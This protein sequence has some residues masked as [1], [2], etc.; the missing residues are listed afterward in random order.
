ML[1]CSLPFW[2]GTLLA[3]TSVNG[4]TAAM[5][6][7]QQYKKKRQNLYF[8][9]LY[10]FLSE[11][12]SKNLYTLY[13][14]SPVILPLSSTSILVAAGTFGRPGMVMISP[15]SASIN[16]APAEILRFLTV[17]SKSVGAPSFVWSSVKLYCVLATQIGQ[18]PN[19]SAYSCFACFWAFAVR[20]TFFPP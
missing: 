15:V 12:P 16:P 20:T 6:N 11:F 17:T 14:N 4:W 2:P 5:S 9:R 19:P 13:Q 1:L 10:R 7:R 8:C 18:L 3:T